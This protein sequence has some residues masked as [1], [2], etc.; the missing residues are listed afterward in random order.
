MAT[1]TTTPKAPTSK[2]GEAFSTAYAAR[3]VTMR[4]DSEHSTPNLGA[5]VRSTRTALGEISQMQLGTNKGKDG[6]ELVKGLQTPA[7]LGEKDKGHRKSGWFSHVAN[8]EQG[9]RK[10]PVDPAFVQYIAAVA[11]VPVSQVEALVAEDASL[12]TA[13]TEANTAS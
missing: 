10:T 13:S 12:R 1:A 11:Q 5:L 9:G 8:I 3:I 6:K 4:A 7:A 2:L